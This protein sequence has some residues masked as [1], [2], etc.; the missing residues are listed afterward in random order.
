MTQWIDVVDSM[1]KIGL[2]AL[3]G[4]GASFA[5]ESHRTHVKRVEEVVLRRTSLV[6]EPVIAFMDEVL[7]AIS[8][9]YWRSLE[10]DAVDYD[11]MKLRDRHA[12]IEARVAALD[13]EELTKEWKRF[14]VSLIRVRR[15]ISQPR[16]KDAYEEM[17]DASKSDGIILRR[18][19]ELDRL[20]DVRRL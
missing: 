16:D 5:V 9:F 3:I 6:V 19:L 18:L 4:G 17:A 13:D 11:L 14:S 1:I 12:A 7:A 15:S 8:Q 20:V 2:G 10:G